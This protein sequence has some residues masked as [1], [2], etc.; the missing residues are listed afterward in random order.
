MSQEFSSNQPLPPLSIGNVVSTGIVLYR[1][2]FKSYF[3]IALRATLW[4]LP[5]YVVT[6]AI[7]IN[8]IERINTSDNSILTNPLLILVLIVSWFALLIYCFAKYLTNSALISRLTFFELI[9]QPESVT[10]ARQQTDHKMW[11]FLR[12]TVQVTLLLFV[13]YLAT[14][15]LVGLIFGILVGLIGFLLRGSTNQLV[16]GIIGGLVITIGVV[17]F[18]F[19][20]FWFISRWLIVEVP[21]AV[22]ENIN[23]SQSIARSWELTEKQVLKIQGILLVSSLVS[24]PIIFFTSYLPQIPLLFLEQSS[25]VYWLVY[26]IGLLMSLVTGIFILPFWQT[27]K[28][29]IYYDLRNRREGLDLELTD[30]V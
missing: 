7:S 5:L 12:V 19:I 9:N 30:S 18:L 29:V 1:S 8:L 10:T 20:L 17:T 24:L 11:S 21:L 23:G 26:P 6:V 14:A 13:A 2:H 3:S 15:L 22:E 27:I 28:A 16:V 25:L 4:M